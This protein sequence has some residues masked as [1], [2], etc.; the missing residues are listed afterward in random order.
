MTSFNHQ[1][2]QLSYFLNWFFHIFLK[3]NCVTEDIVKAWGRCTELVMVDGLDFLLLC[4]KLTETAFT[5]RLVY[6]YDEETVEYI[7]ITEAL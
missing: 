2:A 4:L 5:V 7:F 6:V 3:V 1:S